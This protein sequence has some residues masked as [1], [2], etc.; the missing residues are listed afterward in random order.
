[1][2]K[3]R[4]YP[5][6]KPLPINNQ[7]ELMNNL[8]VV[9]TTDDGETK[10]VLVPKGYKTN[11]ADIPRVFWEEIGTPFSPKFITAVIVHDYHCDIR[12]GKIK[13]KMI[14]VDEMSDLFFDLLREDSVGLVKAFSMEQAVRLYKTII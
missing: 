4:N 2:I 5:T 3:Y 10:A 9:Y 1:M 7:Y 11:G 14:S 12:N 13:S 8:Y 6:L